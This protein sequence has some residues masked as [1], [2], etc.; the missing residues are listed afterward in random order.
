[1]GVVASRWEMG[2][3]RTASCNLWRSCLVK[4]DWILVR[5]V[6]LPLTR[7]LGM[8]S[9]SS[10]QKITYE[11]LGSIQL[12]QYLAVTFIIVHFYYYILVMLCRLFTM[13]LPPFQQT[14]KGLSSALLGAFIMGTLMCACFCFVYA[15]L[16]TC[17]LI[18]GFTIKQFRHTSKNIL[19]WISNLSLSILSLICLLHLFISRQRTC[20][21]DALLHRGW[22][23]L[24]QVSP[25]SYWSDSTPFS[26][27]KK[28]PSRRHY[29]W[30]FS[31][32]RTP[33]CIVCN[34]TSP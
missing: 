1:M 2:N 31:N 23:L 26:Q 34:Q 25:C 33:P 11:M 32:T 4:H 3:V 18:S 13:S 7:F 14:G 27:R 16:N 12:W 19:N 28:S 22:R 21:T 20:S 10:F 5:L 24:K 6:L 15:Q 30:S 29:E 9:S 17:H 8:G